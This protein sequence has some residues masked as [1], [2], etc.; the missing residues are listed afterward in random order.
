MRMQFDI[1]QREILQNANHNLTLTIRLRMKRY[2]KSE[3]RYEYLEKLSP[4]PASELWIP[5]WNDN[6]KRV[7]QSKY[8][9]HK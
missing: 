6:L 7:V 5:I 3:I 2:A 8:I 4:K 1:R 9:V